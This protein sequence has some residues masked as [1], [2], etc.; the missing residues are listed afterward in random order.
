MVPM[1]RPLPLP[2]SNRPSGAEEAPSH[3]LIAAAS[4]LLLEQLRMRIEVEAADVERS[5]VEG[6]R[7]CGA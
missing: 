3:L 1:L 5:T 6:L 7:L 2:F 4:A